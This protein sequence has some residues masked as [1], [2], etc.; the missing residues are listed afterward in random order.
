MKRSIKG[1]LRLY[2]HP[3]KVILVSLVNPYLK[4]KLGSRF[5]ELE[6]L[7]KT[8]GCEVI[9]KI[10]QIREAPDPKFYIG[11]GKIYEIKKLIEENGIDAIIFDTSLSGKYHRNLEEELGVKI[12]D[13]VELIMDIFAQ[14][15][16]TKEAKIQVELAQL[17]YRLT[18]LKGKGK[19]LSRLGGGIGTRGPGEKKLEVDRRRIIERI[20]VLNKELEKIEIMRRERSKRRRNL[21]QITLVGYTNAGKSSLMNILTNSQVEVKDALFSTL[22][23]TTRRMKAEVDLPVILTDTVGFIEDLPAELLASFHSTL[24]CVKEADILIEV[25][26]VSEENFLEKMQIVEETLVSLDAINI[27]RIF[28]FNKIDLVLD[29]NYIKM[30][31]KRFE[32]SFLISCKTQEGIEELK[33][34]L[35]QKIYELLKFKFFSFKI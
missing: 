28:A 14:H 1:K 19:E 15:A 16:R 11:K 24:S 22:D 18:Q 2:I 3:E 20:R 26:D 4:P 27:P 29:K 7:A 12:I 23:T 30:V 35:I 5:M 33:N 25:V 31:S 32:D 21:I 34:F 8:A 6:S 9:G 10:Y 13:R 17:K